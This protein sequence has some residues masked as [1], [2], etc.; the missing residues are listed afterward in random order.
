MNEKDLAKLNHPPEELMDPSWQQLS[1]DAAVEDIVFPKGINHGESILR[2]RYG[3][4]GATCEVYDALPKDPDEILKKLQA[5]NAEIKTLTGPSSDAERRMHKFIT[6]MHH[7]GAM[8]SIPMHK[9]D[10]LWPEGLLSPED[11][12]RELIRY[13]QLREKTVRDFDGDSMILPRTKPNHE[14]EV[15]W[16]KKQKTVGPVGQ[17]KAPRSKRKTKRQAQKQSRKN[18]RK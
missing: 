10:S 5:L 4:E 1:L 2:R 15:I 18:N 6:L 8:S 16:K 9:I 14:P 7:A 11:P 12:E 13:A 3:P 17:G